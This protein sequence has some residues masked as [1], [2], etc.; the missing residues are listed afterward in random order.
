MSDSGKVEP[1]IELEFSVCNSIKGGSGKSTFSVMLASHYAMKEEFACVIDLDICGTSLEKTYSNFFSNK[2]YNHIND[3]MWNC[4]FNLS[5]KP[6][7]LMLRPNDI[8]KPISVDMYLAQSDKAKKTVDEVEL[9]LFVEVIYILVDYIVNQQKEKFITLNDNASN[10]VLKLHFVL[11][12]PPSYEKHAERVVNWLLLGIGSSL[13]KKYPGFKVRLY[14]ISSLSRAHMDANTH[15]LEGICQPSY[16]GKMYRK[17][18]KDIFS[19]VPVFNDV[20]GMDKSGMGDI[21]E[22][23]VKQYASALAGLEVN[24]AEKKIIEHLK[25]LPEIGFYN[26]DEG[27]IKSTVQ[28]DEQSE[29]P[30]TIKL[31]KDGSNAVIENSEITEKKRGNT[32]NEKS[33]YQYLET[34]IWSTVDFSYEDSN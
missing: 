13:S 33:E 25:E 9:D 2:D 27:K 7:Q 26:S 15:Y 29:Y 18:A 5:P 28:Q 10:Q 11:D 16:S 31:K 14:L 12:M 34:Q 8:S 17:D 19:V 4:G 21:L 24:L 32:H 30:E 1:K 20:V 6:A 3:L 22:V 23:C